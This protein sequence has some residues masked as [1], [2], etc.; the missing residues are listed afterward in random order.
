MASTDGA[1]AALL[2]GKDRVAAYRAVALAT[3]TTCEAAQSAL[4]SYSSAHTD[5][6]TAF[7]A[8]TGVLRSGGRGI[9]LTWAPS[10]DER[11][12][13]FVGTPERTVV[14]VGK[15]GCE[16]SDAEAAAQLVWS[17]QHEAALP[18]LRGDCSDAEA[19]QNVM[20][21][22]EL[23]GISA[24]NGKPVPRAHI[25][26]NVA[27][28]VSFA[29]AMSSASSSSSSL[30]EKPTAAAAPAKKTTPAPKTNNKKKATP[31]KRKEAD[32]NSFFSVA[33]QTS[34]KQPEQE[35]HTDEM[36]EE[37]KG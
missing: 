33:Q 8:L 12:K 17:A 31:A 19:A 6:A 4:A 23:N 34:T 10:A 14:A 5:T 25:A 3:S 21:T 36:K 35:K 22:G 9:V 7:V 26:H 11:A 1:V 24:E 37:D 29:S 15:A 20:M 18:L 2:D 16:K 28:N 30:K 32:L 27:V 13:E